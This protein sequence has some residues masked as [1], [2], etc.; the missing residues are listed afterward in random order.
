MKGLYTKLH[1]PDT[2]TS[3]DVK[4]IV[5]STFDFLNGSDVQFPVEGQGEQVMLE[6]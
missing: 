3:S 4:N 1:C 2:C 6:I 5:Y